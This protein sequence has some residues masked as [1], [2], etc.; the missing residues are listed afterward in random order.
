LHLSKVL[1]LRS[2]ADPVLQLERAHEVIKKG[3]SL[4]NSRLGEVSPARS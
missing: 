3:I 4:K 1:V 2:I